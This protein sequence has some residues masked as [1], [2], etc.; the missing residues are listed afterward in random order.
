MYLVTEYR[1]ES[2]E[3]DAETYF[4]E[5]EDANANESD[6]DNAPNREEFGIEL[7]DEFEANELN[8]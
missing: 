5:E 4:S 7:N 1:N 2:S 3:S 8:D 6:S